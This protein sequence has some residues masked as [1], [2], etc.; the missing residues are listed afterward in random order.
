K[1]KINKSI[2][3]VGNFRAL[4]RPEWFLRLAMKFPK[5][6]FIMVGYPTNKS[7]YEYCLDLSES[8]ENLNFLGPI[9]FRKSEK[10][11][12]NAKVLIC[13]SELEGFPNTFLQ[14]WSR[15][16]PVIS[17]VNPSN[18]ISQ[19]NLGLYVNSENDLQNQLERVLY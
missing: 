11:F 5:E 13:S 2:I 14:A 15:N 7:L 18:L 19:K 17:T 12:D 8:I 1:S 10:L 4:K 16:I 9:S 3:W 6:N